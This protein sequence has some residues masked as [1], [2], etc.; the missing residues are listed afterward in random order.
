MQTIFF[1]QVQRGEGSYTFLKSPH[2][3]KIRAMI[4][5]FYD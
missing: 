2:L 4:Q 5:S 1:E 3:P